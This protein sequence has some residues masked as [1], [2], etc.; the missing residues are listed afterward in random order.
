[1]GEMAVDDA[2]EDVCEIGVRIDAAQF[3][4]FDQRGDH[5]PILS[6]VIRSCEER[7][8]AIERDR[9]DRPLD[10]IGVDLDPAVVEEAR[11]AAPVRERV[12][13]DLGELALLT[14][15]GEPLA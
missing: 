7:V 15:E 2:R 1:M 14:D 12:A 9:A 11:E 4:C 6:A 10:G 3:A 5:G 8:L 13:N